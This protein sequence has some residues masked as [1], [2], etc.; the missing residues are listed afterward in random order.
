MV[1]VKQEHGFFSLS[2]PLTLVARGS[3]FSSHS[4]S[5]V[6]I[7]SS[8]ASIRESAARSLIHRITV[9]LS[10]PPVRPPL[11]EYINGVLRRREREGDEKEKKTTP[12]MN[13]ER[14]AFRRQ[15]RRRWR[16][17]RWRRRRRRWPPCGAPASAL[18]SIKENQAPTH[19]CVIRRRAL[20]VYLSCWM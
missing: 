10:P 11:I 1:V 9:I 16:R 13:R 15:R 2:L 18:F 14:R 20:S 6:H 7:L 5:C 19:L 12:I 4:I 17:R 3:L 8:R